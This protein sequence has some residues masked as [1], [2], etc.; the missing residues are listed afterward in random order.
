MARDIA[1]CAADAATSAPVGEAWELLSQAWVY[2]SNALELE[3]ESFTGVPVT[4]KGHKGSRL[5]A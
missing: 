2:F 5:K 3:L 4:S 1:E